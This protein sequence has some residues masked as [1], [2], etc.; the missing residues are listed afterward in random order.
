MLT[1][2]KVEIVQGDFSLSADFPVEAGAMVSVIGPSGAGKSTLL[3]ALA[4]FVPITSGRIF[5]QGVDISRAAPAGRP[6]AM[7]FQDS[8]LFPHLTV[9]QNV[10]LGVKPSLKLAAQEHTRVAEALARVGLSG[11]EARKAAALSGGQQSRVALARV[12]L[13]DK[14][15]MVLDEPF[16]ALGPALRVEMLALMVE[17]AEERGLTVLMVTHD[18]KDA[19][20]LN[21]ST[22]LVADGIAHAPVPTGPF[23]DAPPDVL[24][25][26]LGG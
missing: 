26:Y 11:F 4:G 22:I 3:S 2:D 9:A 19:R 6:L 13:R 20:Q 25:A 17:I 5:W 21:G 12:L 14:P 8:N 15:V 1:F 23:L 24:R 18:P 16:A 7:V 10:G